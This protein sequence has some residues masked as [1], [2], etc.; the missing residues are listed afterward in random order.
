MS[1]LLFYTFFL[2]IVLIP[3]YLFKTTPSLKMNILHSVIFAL[4][5]L[6]TH[7]L[8]KGQKEGLT[9]NMF[10]GVR[11]KASNIDGWEKLLN[12]IFSAHEIRKSNISLNVTNGNGKANN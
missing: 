8:V 12:T 7:D 9:S 3:N 11:I 10:D 1:L 5:Y 6:C 2:F 4:I